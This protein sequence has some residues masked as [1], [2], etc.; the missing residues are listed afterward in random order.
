MGEVVCWKSIFEYSPC[1]FSLI[2]TGFSNAESLDSLLLRAFEIQVQLICL[3]AIRDEEIR[4]HFDVVISNRY[5]QV[6]G[7]EVLQTNPEKM[8]IGHLSYATK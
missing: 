2:L 8:N 5:Y 4:T 7:R 3:T 1:K 6:G